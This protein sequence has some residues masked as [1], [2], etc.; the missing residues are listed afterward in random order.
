LAQIAP[1]EAN[2]EHI[3]IRAPAVGIVRALAEP[4]TYVDDRRPVGTISILGRRLV[5]M[6]PPGIAGWVTETLVD[7]RLVAVGYGQ[8]L[9]R[10]AAHGPDV[11]AKDTRL[12][13]TAVGPF[14]AGKQLTAVKSPS[15]GVFYRRSAPETPAYVEVG[16]EV[17]PGA[18]L[19][20]IEIM[21]CFHQITYDGGAAPARGTVVQILAPDA[22]EVRVGQILFWIRPSSIAP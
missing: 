22:A 19:G 1:R 9:L 21:K 13:P 10:L 4:G 16:T 12:S 8:P 14:D 2:S 15:D 18:V 7:G 20:L 6:L 5:L 3:E 17:Q 11:A